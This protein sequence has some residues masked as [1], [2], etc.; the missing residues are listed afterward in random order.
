[1]LCCCPDTDSDD[2]YTLQDTKVT[3]NT[4]TD[5]EKILSLKEVH[6]RASNPQS[7][8]IQEGSEGEIKRCTEGDLQLEV[9]EEVIEERFVENCLA[10][11]DI[12][13]QEALSSA[14]NRLEAVATRLES[15]AGRSG[16]SSRSSISEPGRNEVFRLTHD[17]MY[18]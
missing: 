5:S 4:D 10:E 17:Q 14:V 16:G 12:M 13:S 7:E 18:V 9:Q 11:E 8:E 1:M 3:K 2:N 6:S 15:L